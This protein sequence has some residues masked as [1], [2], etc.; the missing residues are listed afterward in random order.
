M[1]YKQTCLTEVEH[2]VSYHCCSRSRSFSQFRVYISSCW[3]YNY[4]GI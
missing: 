1:S 3:G 2:R 4:D